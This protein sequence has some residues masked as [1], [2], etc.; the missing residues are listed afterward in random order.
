MEKEDKKTLLQIIISVVLFG[1]LLIIEHFVFTNIPFIAVFILYLALYIFVAHGV[2]LEAFE[3]IREGEVFDENFLMCIASIGAM[4]IGFLPNTEPQFAEAVAVVLFYRIGE[5]FEDIAV[6]KSKKSITSLM[7]LK[8]E[9]ANIIKDG[10]TIQV[11]PEDIKVDD[12]ILVKAGE[13]IP[14]DG[15]IIEGDSTLDTVALTGESI[16]K[17]VTVG[18]NVLNGCINISGVLKIKVKNEYENSTVAKILK[19]VEDANNNKSKSESF[20]KKF[21]KVY[22]PFVVILAVIITFLPP[23]FS[24]DFFGT[25]TT[26]F[27]RAL[28]FLVISCPCALVISV[29]LTFFCGIGGASKQGILIKGS[30]YI[31]ALSKAKTVVFDKT[32]TLTKGSFEVVEICPKGVSEND[33][34]KIVGSAEQF[35]NHPIAISIKN[36]L[37][38]SFIP[39]DF[40]DVKEISGK[41][42]TANYKNNNIFVGNSAIMKLA[43]AK[44]EEVSTVGTVIY[45]SVGSTYLGYIVIADKVK[46]DSKDTIKSLNKLGITKTVMLSG[47]KDEI[48]KSSAVKLGLSEYKA[49]LLPADKVSY[50]QSIMLRKQDT[51]KVIYV[52]DGIND[53]PVL[54]RADIGIAMGK[55]GSDA[56][57]EAADV[58][59]MDDNP[60]KIP[61]CIG[62]SKKILRIVKENIIFAL[63]AKALIML[64]G[65]LGIAGMW[66]AVVADVGVAIIAILNAT[67]ALKLE[68]VAKATL[69]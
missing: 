36:K 6:D 42:I 15:V 4:L 69:K 52:G 68:Y 12:I 14:L 33:L 27:T 54:A 7:N 61:I 18:D 45:V 5:F 43:N 24:G 26:W 37:G 44:Y 50:M 25:F 47:D 63:G 19:L 23:L 28:T 11:S 9:F 58:V 32:G 13:K 17:N 57:I 22:T 39:F 56:T 67:R 48:A 29:P 55:F 31:E 53:A 34:L 30:N 49:E 3:N 1:I 62:I 16:P 21:A 38:N 35:S 59:L 2:L 60:S 64:L 8:S 10:K 65:V 66:L 46:E 20:I 40:T 41:G 51:S